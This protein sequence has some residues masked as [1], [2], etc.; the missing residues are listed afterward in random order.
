MTTQLNLIGLKVKEWPE[1][2]RTLWLA[3]QKGAGILDEGGFAADWRPA[4]I[5]STERGYGVYLSWLREAHGLDPGAVPME[6]VDQDLMRAFINAYAPGRAET[7]V[8]GMV[9]GVAYVLRA[10]NPPDGLPWLTRLAHK[11]TNEAQP[12]RPKLPRMASISE[13]TGLGRF[14]MLEG[15]DD[16]QTGKV[17]GAPLFRDGLMIASLAAR[18]ELRRRNLSALRLNHSLLRDQIGIRVRFPGKETK[19]SRPMDFHFPDWLTGAF[20]VY[21]EEVRP[22]L[23]RRAQGNDAGWLWIGQR[24]RPLLPGAISTRISA[25]TMRHLGRPVSPHLFRDCA[26]TDIALFI[27][28]HVGITKSVLGHASLA[29]SQASYNQAT[30]FTAVGR[31]DAVITGLRED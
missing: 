12:S 24:G 10:T 3:A 9:R 29:S 5:Q 8:A 6:R 7:T 16:L 26:A 27:P 18:P 4:T 1:R 25:T 30:S 14:L 23:L 15:W 20:E 13:L 2:D 28:E 31:L 22:V 11:M 21:V 19:K 17:S